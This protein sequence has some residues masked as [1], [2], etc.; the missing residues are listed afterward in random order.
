MRAV[1]QLQG[2]TDAESDELSISYASKF[3]AFVRGLRCGTTH[4]I[5]PISD[6][7]VHGTCNENI[8]DSNKCIH[9]D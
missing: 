8:H 6:F 2:E 5:C 1:L 3:E 7:I 9:S 4:L